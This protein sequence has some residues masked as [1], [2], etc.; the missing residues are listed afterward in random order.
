MNQLAQTLI[1]GAL[2]GGVYAL[3]ATGLTLTFGVM[4]MTGGGAGSSP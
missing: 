1:F 4:R 3:M 2:L